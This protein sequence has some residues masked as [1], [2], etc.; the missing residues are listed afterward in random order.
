MPHYKDQSNKIHW[1]DNAKFEHLLPSGSVQ[2]SDEDAAELQAPPHP[3]A[4]QLHSAAEANR[5]AAYIAEADPLFFKVQRGE[6]I[7]EEWMAKVAD[8]RARF[9]YSGE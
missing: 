1:L 2:I 5:R 6:A 9:P 7:P 4:E 8:I 3:T